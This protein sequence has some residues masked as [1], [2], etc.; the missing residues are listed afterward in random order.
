LLV[1]VNQPAYMPWLGYFERV[2]IS[3]THVVLD[4]VQ[5]EKNSMINRNNVLL[6]GSKVMLTI[7]LLTKGKFQNLP[8]RAVQIDCGQKWIRKHLATIQQGYSKTPF[9]EDFFPYLEQFYDDIN[10]AETLGLVLRKNLEFIVDYLEIETDIIYSSDLEYEGRKSELVLDICQRVGATEYISG[11]FGRDYLDMDS[12]RGENIDVS[13]HDYNHPT[14]S[15]KSTNFVPKLSVIDL[16]FN[17]GKNSRTIIQTLGANL[18]NS[19][20]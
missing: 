13:F 14:Y 17:H 7:P 8:I 4:D 15:Q 18:K 9:F 16:I 3:D 20:D 5:F 1:S 10:G 11:P 6:N 12:F 2:L 19:F